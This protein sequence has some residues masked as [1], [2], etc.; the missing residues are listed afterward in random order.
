MKYRLTP[1]AES[2]LRNIWHY[3]C[4]N[5][6]TMQAEKYLGE[7]DVCLLKICSGE[8]FPKDASVLIHDVACEE[9]SF[10]QINSHYLILRKNGDY[11]D[12]LSVLYNRMDISSHVARLQKMLLM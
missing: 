12:V 5:W 9:I 3:T 1:K 10:Y 6:G 2:D 7:I 11:Y 4:E 8:Y